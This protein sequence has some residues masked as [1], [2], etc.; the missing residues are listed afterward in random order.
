MR[1]GL[2]GTAYDALS[3]GARERFLRLHGETARL[4]SRDEFLLYSPRDADLAPLFPGPLAGGGPTPFSAARPLHRF[5]L[6]ARWFSR[7]LARDRVDLFITD[8]FPVLRGGAVRTLLTIHD[9]RYLLLPG[10][11]S[12]WRRAWFR[13]R[14]ARTAA[15]PYS[16][17]A[18]WASPYFRCSP[19]SPGLWGITT[20]AIWTPG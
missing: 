12:P 4:R 14:F 20:C 13:R 10:A 9:L 19:F 6:S 1:I 3:S 8:H 15:R 2:N 5:L 18:S 11:G 16:C 17:S 7:R